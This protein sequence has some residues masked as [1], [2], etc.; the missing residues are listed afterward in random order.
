MSSDTTPNPEART[1]RQDEA[2]SR[3]SGTLSERDPTSDSGAT[4]RPPVLIVIVVV[5]LVTA[6]VVL[7]LT[8]VLGPGSH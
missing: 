7:H 8:G 6:F 4:S 1:T 5:L 3:I 2:P